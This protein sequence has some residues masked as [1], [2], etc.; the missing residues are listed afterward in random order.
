MKIVVDKAG[1][2]RVTFAELKKAGFVVPA[3]TSLLQ[4][5][6][7]G[8]EVPLRVTRAGI[9]FYGLPL[10][11]LTT[12]R[13][14]YWLT[15][16]SKPG[17]RLGARRPGGTTGPLALAGV[18]TARAQAKI[19][20]YAAV[21]NG[22]AGNFFTQ[23]V[24][25][26][27]VDVRE[28]V[29]LE[30]VDPIGAG[31]MGV[32]LQGYSTSLHRVRVAVN[33][34]ELGVIEFTGQTRA[35]TEFDVPT[36]ALQDGKNIITL[37]GLGGELDYS[38]VESVVLTYRRL[39]LAD[40]GVLDF[41]LP[42]RQRARIDGFPHRAVR[43]M[44]VTTPTAPAEIRA[45]IRRSARGFAATIGA[46]PRARHLTAFVDEKALRP[47]TIAK[48]GPSTL[49]ASGRGAD[50]LIITHRRFAPALPP[51]VAARRSAGLRVVVAD[52]E[53]VYDEFAFGAHGPQAISGF[54]SWTRAQW[55]PAPR[56][57]LLVGDASLDPLNHYGLGD[58]DFVPTKLVDTV[59][60]EA[61]SDD[62]LADFDDDSLPELAV[63]RLPVQTL[64][65]ARAVVAKLRRYDAQPPNA[66]GEMLLVSD[67]RI[68]YDFEAASR[69]LFG[70]IPPTW[71]VQEVK[72]AEGPTDAAVRT[73]LLEALG[74]GPT[75]VNF[76]GH[77][78]TNIW[79]SGEILSSKHVS[80]LR[81]DRLS[82]YV[83]M[84]CLNGY[85]VN[86]GKF[87]SLG[88]AL[89]YNPSGGAAAVWSSTGETVPTDQIA[90]D[91]KALAL[92][93]ENPDMTLGEAMLQAKA[94]IRDEDV[95]RTWVLFG[96]PTMHLR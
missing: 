89:L 44:D 13:Q 74:R 81:N 31:T 88:E 40:R 34:V 69:T 57:V 5:Y 86:P 26:G 64:E 21:R 84:T 48:N 35:T 55:K 17:L 14:T 19:G 62:S 67:K 90:M 72:R 58:S 36:G 73:R 47:A 38:L 49:H 91:Q 8:Q 7:E 93:F 68:D 56:F 87:T 20:Y 24:V 11:T 83:M 61:P 85:F 23:M 46:A 95:R 42:A 28:T 12:D 10:D 71:T 78:A 79:T 70:L 52:V 60:L 92:L 27:G 63:G 15:A 39:L 9:E 4:V 3:K 80:S 2:Y 75:I 32:A 82:L 18:A 1:W 96:D 37:R 54:L 50:L 41:V 66:S 65:Q 33:G 94:A 25:R 16:G 53:D 43:V 59:Y 29:Q 22:E 45:T 30:G 6:V 76:F 51:L 77:G